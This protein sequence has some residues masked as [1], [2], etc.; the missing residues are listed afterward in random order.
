M[1]ASWSPEAVQAQAVAARTYAVWN[2]ADSV[3]KGD[4]NDLCDTSSCQVYRGVAGE[5]PRSDA[6][7]KATA[8]EILRY[9][10]E[11]AFTQFSSS[12]G[13]WTTDGGF[14]YLPAEKDP[15]DGVPSNPNH[16][17]SLKLRPARIAAAFPGI[18]KLRRIHVTARD[19]HG[20]WK[21]RVES[22]TL[23][24]SKGKHRMTGDD[25]RLAFGL[26]S[27]WFTFK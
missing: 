25:F 1:P 10:G 7:V 20:Q 21:G 22:M 18:G 9:D 17:W 11:P 27:T 4:P 14:P 23:V 5:D 24:G 13:G 26:R 6:A 3:P 15:Y 12:S 2:R 19:G 8:G 16:T